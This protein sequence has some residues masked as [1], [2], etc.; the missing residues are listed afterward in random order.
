M[1]NLVIVGS[2]NKS[3][4]RFWVIDTDRNIHLGIYGSHQEASARIEELQDQFMRGWGPDDLAWGLNRG[5][6]SD[7]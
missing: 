4:T 3:D 5:A 7:A 6:C 2:P 1:L